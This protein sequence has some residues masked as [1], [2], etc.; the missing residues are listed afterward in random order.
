M[1]LKLLLP[2]KKIN[3][4]KAALS[5]NYDLIVIAHEA[6][7]P[8]STKTYSFLRELG[9]R[10]TFATKDSRESSFFFH[11]ISIAVQRFNAIRIRDSFPVL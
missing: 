9:R 7:G 6:L 10:L 3:L 11:R 1:S 4:L 8:L 2:E 5:I